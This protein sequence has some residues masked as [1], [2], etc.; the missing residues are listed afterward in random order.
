M[1]EPLQRTSP[2]SAGVPRRLWMALGIAW[3][4][5]ITVVFLF[6]SVPLPYLE[7]VDRWIPGTLTLRRAILSLFYRDY[8][9]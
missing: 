4:A 2:S 5:A 7:E 3:A 9:F 1:T 8:I 6:L